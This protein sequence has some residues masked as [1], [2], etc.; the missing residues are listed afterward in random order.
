M[1]NENYR[2]EG[3]VSKGFSMTKLILGLGHAGAVKAVEFVLLL[4]YVPGG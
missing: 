4:C 1:L 3:E 2:T